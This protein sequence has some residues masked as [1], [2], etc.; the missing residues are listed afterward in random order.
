VN[1][2]SPYRGRLAPS[3]T[4]YLHLGHARTFWTAAARARAAGGT[5]IL[6]SD[7]L[8]A[9]RY[10][11]D[12]AAAMLEDL[13]WLGLDWDEGPDGGGPHAPYE[14]SRRLPRYRAALERL[15][16]AGLVYPCYR[17][18]RDVLEAA[19]APHEGGADDEPLYPAAFRP[20][21]TAPLPAL[22][23]A[24]GANWRLRVPDGQSLGFVDGRLGPQQAVAGRDFG[25]F[26]V[27]RKDGVPS[28]QLACVVDDAE[29]GITEVVRG[30]DLVR[31]TF[32]QLLLFRA[33]GWTVPAFYHC[34]LLTDE[35]GIRL[36]KRH[37]SLSLR[38]LRAQGVRPE[39]LR[40]PWEPA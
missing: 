14:Q 26:P 39:A 32:R 40:Q 13:R 28:Y 35:R 24:E 9:T 5:L 22:D 18:R 15:H 38:A 16:A 10:R 6:R 2:A 25:D 34:A 31:S 1:P 12:F 7:D 17:T 37:D 21:P 23:Q 11:M 27:W 3:P 33:L 36:A 8:D 29:M 4:G 30:E 20:A 19:G